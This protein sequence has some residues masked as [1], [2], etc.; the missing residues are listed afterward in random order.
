M[1][2][3]KQPKFGKGGGCDGLIVGVRIFLLPVFTEVSK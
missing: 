3:P 2:E 1:S